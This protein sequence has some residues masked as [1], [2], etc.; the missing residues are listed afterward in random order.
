MYDCLWQLVHVCVCVCVCVC[1]CCMLPLTHRHTKI[2]L[3]DTGLVV[4]GRVRQG[5]HGYVGGSSEVN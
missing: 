4:P 3:S 5:M 2:W 1:A